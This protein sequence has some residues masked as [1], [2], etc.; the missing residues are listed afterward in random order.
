MAKI[1]VYAELS[2]GGAVEKTVF[3]ILT[4]AR[5]LGADALECVALGPGATAAAAALGEYGATTVYASD[6]DT[7]SDFV[8]EP[9]AHVIA[10]LI[11][12]HQ[13]SLVLAPFTYDA[14][15]TMARVSAKLGLTLHTGATDVLAVD[16]TQEAIF[17]GAKIVDVALGG[18]E[19]RI[20]L[21]RPKFTEAEP[22]GGAAANVVNVD[23]A[24]P[25]ETKR[26]RRTERHEE[27]ATGPKL[28]EAPVVVSGGR[29]LQQAE[30]FKLLEDLAAAIGN[31]AVGASRAVV[32]A[33]WVPY[34][35]QIGQTGKTV[36]PKVY[37]ACGIS[38]ATQ[39]IVGMKS[40]E[41][42]IAINKDPDA[43]IFSLADLGIVGDALKVIP[44][45]TD[46]V[47]SRKG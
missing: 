37:I 23:V 15:D 41:R 3:E 11:K 21:L 20:V 5:T 16:K 33:G 17:G 22:A 43:P 28:E 32:D 24:V 1:W 39:H 13:P 38:G 10:E 44:Q 9:A 27:D 18:N 46:E 36:K 6:D 2:H 40:S 29:G 4:K 30:N 42:I 34:S 7:F 12:Q 19:P 26:A 14:R 35:M 47:K 31:A 45:L 25:D 8:A